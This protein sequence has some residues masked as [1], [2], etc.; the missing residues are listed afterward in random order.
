MPGS[1]FILNPIAFRVSVLARGLPALMFNKIGIKRIRSSFRSASILA[2]IV[3]PVDRSFFPVL[4]QELSMP[5]FQRMNLME[6]LKGN[7]KKNWKHAL[8]VVTT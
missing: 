2:P 5:L 8:V 4:L 1:G 3:V 6:D 7:L